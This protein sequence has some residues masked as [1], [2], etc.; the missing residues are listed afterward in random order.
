MKKLF[1]ILRLPPEAE[2]YKTARRLWMALAL[3]GL[4][5][6]VGVLSLVFSATA[7]VKLDSA[8]LF[9]SYL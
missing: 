7:Y 5:C 9:R 8:A 1:R 3:T 2:E 4:G 6:C